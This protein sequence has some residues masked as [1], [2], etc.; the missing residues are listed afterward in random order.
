MS[1][2][3]PCNRGLQNTE[4]ARPE[5]I[6]QRA[7]AA[8]LRSDLTDQELAV[9]TAA[10]LGLSTREAADLLHISPKTVEHHL[11]NIYRK[12][13][14]R[15]R[16]QLAGTIIQRILTRMLS[17]GC[18]RMATAESHLLNA[19]D[20]VTISSTGGNGPDEEP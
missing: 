11:S 5:L 19:R 8:T 7:I 12:L 15:S 3:T 1:S 10:A 6:S 13:N 2:V 16:S 20:P 17:T 4:G 9:A 14:V 18:P